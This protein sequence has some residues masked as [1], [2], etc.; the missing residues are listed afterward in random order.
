MLDRTSW[1]RAGLTSAAL[2]LCLGACDSVLGI[3]EPSEREAERGEAG[4]PADTKKPGSAG[5]GGDTSSPSEGGA[6]GE[7]PTTFRAGGAGDAGHGGSPECEPRALRCGG[8]AEAVPERCDDSGHWVMNPNEN[9]GEAC[10][11]VCSGGKCVECVDDATQCTSCPEGNAQ[12]NPRQRQQCVDGQWVDHGAACSH[13]C[14]V[15]E[16][17]IPR[18]CNGGGERVTC[19]GESCCKSLAVPAGSFKRD[20]DGMDPFESEAWP[21]EVSAVF[22]DRYEVNVGRFRAFVE[23]YPLSLKRGQG[24]APHIADDDGWTEAL[25]ADL[26]A[27]KEELIDSLK[28]G[29]E[30]WNEAGDNDRLPINCVDFAVAYAFCV[31]DGGR[32][33]TNA[34][35]NYAAVGGSLH[36]PYAWGSELDKSHV[37]YDDSGLAALTLPPEVGSKSAGNGRWGHADL[38]GSL[39]EWVLDYHQEEFTPANCKDCVNTTGVDRTVRG[40]SFLSDALTLRSAVRMPESPSTRVSYIGFRCAR[41]VQS[42]E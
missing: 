6:G 34:E 12:C 10:P 38:N 28:C 20:Y 37:E 14:D 27:T 11:A 41:D 42:S 2:L 30:T 4:A 18:S 24:K 19:N 25:A 40:G 33:P 17:Q 8:E 26:P 7:G 16:C 5:A 23:A 1:Q 39:Q 32:L 21:A 36:R 31:W 3:E 15:G 29:D 35:W 9:G 22:I 13:F